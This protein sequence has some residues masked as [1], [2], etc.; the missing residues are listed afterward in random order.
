MWQVFP[1]VF[2][3]Q[4][5]LLQ[6]Q[7][8]KHPGQELFF[9]SWLSLAWDLTFRKFSYSQEAD[10]SKTRDAVRKKTFKAAEGF[11]FTSEVGSLGCMHLA[12]CL[13]QAPKASKFPELLENTSSFKSITFQL[14]SIS[15]FLLLY[16][17]V[18]T[19]WLL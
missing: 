15:A 2:S 7:V 17:C 5:P 14:C 6:I 10:H 11:P 1:S 8:P 12:H 16:Y 3:G 9:I 13:Y 18:L 19:C 4:N